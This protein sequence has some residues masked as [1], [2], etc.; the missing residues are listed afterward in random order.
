[1]SHLTLEWQ[2]GL[3]FKNAADSPA[4]E[5]HSSTTGITSPTQALAYATMACMGMD[6]VHV[7]QKGR[8]EL[9][10][11]SVTF[12]G[13]RADHEPRRYLAMSLHFTLTGRVDS[14]VVERAIEL[15]RTKYCSV[16]HSLREDI[17][18][19]TSYRIQEP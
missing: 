4:I 11:M 7:I 18:L 12:E 1:M 15:S 10:A 5:L 3:A 2:G 19:K 17:S 8:H 9:T 13:Q 6:V 16:W 14:H